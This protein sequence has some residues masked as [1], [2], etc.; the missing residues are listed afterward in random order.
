VSIAGR[1][2]VSHEPWYEAQKAMERFNVASRRVSEAFG[3]TLRISSSSERSVSKGCIEGV[4]TAHLTRTVEHSQSGKRS[5][6]HPSRRNW[7]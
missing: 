1:K 5:Q 7:S 3:G 6:S 2:G 4:D